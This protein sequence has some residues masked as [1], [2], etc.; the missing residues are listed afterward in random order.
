[1]DE[2]LREMANGPYATYKG[3]YGKL[4]S[5]IDSNNLE[6]LD[7]LAFPEG[8][9]F[10]GFVESSVGEYKYPSDGYNGGDVEKCRNY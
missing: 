5:V 4:R 10:C 9:K 6:E 8:R 7:K 1:M 3:Y 2:F